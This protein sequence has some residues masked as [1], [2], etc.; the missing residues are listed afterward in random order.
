MTKIV[1]TSLKAGEAGVIACINSNVVVNI[2][3]STIE[4]AATL[5]YQIVGDA[6]K[7]TGGW[8]VGGQIYPEALSTA[9]IA[10]ATAMDAQAEAAIENLRAY[11]NLASP[12]N[13]Q[14][15]AAVKLLCRVVIGLVRLRLGRLDSTL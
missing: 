4:F 9:E 6:I 10:N 5:G 11:A 14:T 2:I 15:I 7:V 12:S 8:L 3:R 1:R 13:A